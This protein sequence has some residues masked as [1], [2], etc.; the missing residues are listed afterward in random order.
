MNYPKKSAQFHVT[1]FLNDRGD[2]TEYR[3][4]SELLTMGLIMM[5][6]VFFIAEIVTAS[7]LGVAAD[8]TRYLVVSGAYIAAFI[9]AY[10]VLAII[11]KAKQ[12]NIYKRSYAKLSDS[13]ADLIKKELYA[14]F[15]R[16]SKKTNIMFFSFLA[17][18]IAAGGLFGGLY[19]PQTQPFDIFLQLLG[20]MSFFVLIAAFASLI[21]YIFFYVR[22]VKKISPKED[23]LLS[24]L[25][26]P[27]DI[28]I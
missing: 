9:A 2:E 25:Y 10:A 14:E 8:G 4:I 7:L 15:R 20:S 24:L 6:A 18:G 13:P 17:A 28:R 22:Y 11:A 21:V 3:R 16:H 12:K 27:S 5:F 23:E 26:D 1:V 19:K